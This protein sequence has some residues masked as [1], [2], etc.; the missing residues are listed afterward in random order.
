MSLEEAS[1]GV[2]VKCCWGPKGTLPRWVWRQSSFFDFRESRSL[3]FAKMTYLVN[4]P[5]EFF[6]PPGIEA[7]PSL[8]SNFHG[9]LVRIVN[10]QL[11]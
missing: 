5:P 7:V 10:M 8:R 1:G 2:A 6:R 9:V 11:V 3:E 4:L